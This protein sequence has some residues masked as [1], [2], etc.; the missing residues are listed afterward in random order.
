MRRA[1]GFVNNGRV[2]GGFWGKRDRELNPG[3][4]R[5]KDVRPVEGDNRWQARL[6]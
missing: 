5:R 3:E 1:D 6:N 4:N 2:I